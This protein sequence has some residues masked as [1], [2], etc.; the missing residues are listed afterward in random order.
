MPDRTHELMP[1]HVIE[2]YR[3]AKERRGAWESHWEV[4]CWNDG[5]PNRWKMLAVGSDDP[6]FKICLRIARRALAGTL[7]DPTNGATHYHAKSM[8][9]PWARNRE[10]SAEIGNHRFYNDVE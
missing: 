4:S 10:P 1:K 3:R 2:R 6:V 7:K 9:P 8:T 5:D